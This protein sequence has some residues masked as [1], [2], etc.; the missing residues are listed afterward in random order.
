MEQIEFL[1]NQTPEDMYKNA[2]EH[3]AWCENIKNKYRNLKL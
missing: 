2:V 1:K 3:E